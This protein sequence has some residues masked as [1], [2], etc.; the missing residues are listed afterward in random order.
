M[1]LELS[2]SYTLF[3]K[4]TIIGILLSIRPSHCES[5]KSRFYDSLISHYVIKRSLFHHSTAATVKPKQEQ[6]NM[7]PVPLLD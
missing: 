6:K 5:V 2:P 7:S 3:L 4:I 1:I